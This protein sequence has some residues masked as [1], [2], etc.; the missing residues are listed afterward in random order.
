[1]LGHLVVEALYKTGALAGLPID[2]ARRAA[3][4]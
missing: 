2:R 1:V 3:Q 4:A